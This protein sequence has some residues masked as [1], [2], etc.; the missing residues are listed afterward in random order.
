MCPSVVCMQ[1]LACCKSTGPGESFLCATLDVSPFRWASSSPSMTWKIVSSTPGT[2]VCGQE[3]TL[4][5][6]VKMRFLI[7]TSCEICICSEGLLT[8]E[9]V[10]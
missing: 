9:I 1:R 3:L 2:Q 8:S 7:C 10:S 4:L 6:G 5:K